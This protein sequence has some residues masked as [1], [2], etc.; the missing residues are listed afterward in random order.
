MGIVRCQHVVIIKKIIIHLKIEIIVQN[1]IISDN[2]KY[3]E[4]K[5]KFLNRR[6]KKSERA[7][8]P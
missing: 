4:R 8:N 7:M 3:Y 2:L 6:K 1:D 5:Y